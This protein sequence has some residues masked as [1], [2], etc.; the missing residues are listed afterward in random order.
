MCNY[1]E[2]SLHHTRPSH[3]GK[4]L[5]GSLDP[6]DP[7]QPTMGA[8][9]QWQPSCLS[10]ASPFQALLVPVNPKL[11]LQLESQ[12]LFAKNMPLNTIAMFPLRTYTLEK[13]SP[14]R[15]ILHPKEKKGM[16][17]YFTFVSLWAL[18]EL[19]LY[20]K[21]SHPEHSSMSWE[22]D[23]MSKVGE[24]CLRGAK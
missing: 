13:M 5:Q 24:V 9:S 19:Q 6:V 8:G 23:A 18:E 11:S 2:I 10:P 20:W 4:A 21:C 3:T 7:G 14:E 1:L 12:S 15:E 17:A 22:Y 16:C